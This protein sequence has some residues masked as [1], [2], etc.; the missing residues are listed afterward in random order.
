MTDD[1]DADRS[2]D[3]PPDS[4][5]GCESRKNPD[6]SADDPL[7]EYEAYSY[8]DRNGMKRWTH[9]PKCHESVMV[10]ALVEPTA[11]QVAPCGCRLPPDVL[12]RQ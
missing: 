3:L 1:H 9:C 7:C 5:S 10:V 11:A 6:S 8:H 4:R 2:S 12:K